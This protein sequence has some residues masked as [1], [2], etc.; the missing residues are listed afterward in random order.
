MGETFDDRVRLVIEAMAA[1]LGT[2]EA[3]VKIIL[4]NQDGPRLPYP[5]G[6]YSTPTTNGEEPHQRVIRDAVKEGDPDTIVETQS[7]TIRMNI[8]L[9]FAGKGD[10]APLKALAHKARKWL[11][12]FAGEDV[13]AEQGLVARLNGP[14]TDRSVL[15]EPAFEQRVGFD[16]R[17][18]GQDEISQEIEIIKTAGINGET[19]QIEPEA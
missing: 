13:C 17:L 16:F 12:T 3:P 19:V 10:K 2:E 14:L 1:A 5:F 4:A 8:S 9:Y 18:D 15:Q 7:E 11:S 6:V